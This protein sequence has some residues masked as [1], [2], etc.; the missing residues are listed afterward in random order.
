MNMYN[1]EFIYILILYFII[2]NVVNIYCNNCI[3]VLVYNLLLLIEYEYRID[4][5]FDC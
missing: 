4:L 5:H 3:F 1:I 2:C